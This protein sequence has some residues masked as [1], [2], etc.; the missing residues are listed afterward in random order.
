MHIRSIIVISGAVVLMAATAAL[1]K[2]GVVPKID[3]EKQC[4]KSQ[5]VTD[6][7]TATKNPGSFDLCIKNEQSARDKLIERGQ[8]SRRRTRHSVFI[9]HNFHQAISN[10]LGARDKGLR[11]KA[12]GEG[13]ELNAH[14]RAVPDCEL[15]LKRRN[16]Q[17]RRMSTAIEPILVR[18]TVDHRNISLSNPRSRRDHALI[19]GTNS[20]SSAL[21]CCVARALADAR[22]AIIL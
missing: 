8:L 15:E 22:L 2:D 18:A 13:S 4:T 5:Q 17:C 3:L 19:A 7:L 6:S 20:L 21:S 11:A 9:Q 1:S 16:H 14:L 10:G 12:A